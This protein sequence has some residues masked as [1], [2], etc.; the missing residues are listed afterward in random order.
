MSS[1]QTNKNRARVFA[2]RLLPKRKT[3]FAVLTMRIY[4]YSMMQS[5]IC[6]KTNRH[7]NV[8]VTPTGA[9]VDVFIPHHIYTHTHTHIHKSNDFGSK[10]ARTLLKSHENSQKCLKSGVKWIEPVVSQIIRTKQRERTES[11]VGRL[12]KVSMAA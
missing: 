3:D 10:R 6:Y 2:P 5:G 11:K 1:S 7:D 8:D 12:T 4:A 9:A